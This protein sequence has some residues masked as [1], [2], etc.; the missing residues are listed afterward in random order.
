[1]GFWGSAFRAVGRSIGRGIQRVG[2]FFGS[3]TLS[4]VG[5]AIQENCSDRVASE[6]SYN[7]RTASVHTTDRLNEILVSFSEGYF[8][9]ATV[10]EKDC[11]RLVE[12]YYDQLI[13]VIENVPNE[14][15]CTANL[16]A[17]KK[18][19]NKISKTISGAI[20]NPLAKRMSLDDS[21]CLKILKMDS[22]IEKKEA[23]TKFTQKVI[24]EAIDNLV[25]SVRETLNDQTIDIQEYVS[26]LFEE[27]EKTTQVLKEQFDNM[28]SNGMLETSD[29]EKSCIM[30]LY[31]VN[32]SEYVL[33]ILK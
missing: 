5:R 1:M 22:G 9:Q 28:V 31:I 4:N 18:G 6:K 21:E 25:K 27:Q 2:D 19:K 11:I 30:P 20:K 15:R 17:L 13:S 3:N 7:K 14:A 16:K 12:E 23:M 29:R 8:Q 32:T 26:D 10:I 33:D 24:G